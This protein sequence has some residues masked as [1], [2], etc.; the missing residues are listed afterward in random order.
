MSRSLKT[1]ITITDVLFILYWTLAAL[2]QVGLIDIPPAAMYANYEDPI[3][4]A[5]NWSFLP[6]DLIFSYFGLKA[7]AEARRGDPAWR[8]HASIS[9][10]LTMVAGGMAVAYWLIL[11]EFDPS[12]FLPNLALLVW[13]VFFLPRLISGLSGPAP[14][15]ASG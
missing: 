8:I 10:I 11:L 9:L 5:W 1:S 14:T 2:G 12:W 7:V 15:E 4:V 3:V 13:P 6:I